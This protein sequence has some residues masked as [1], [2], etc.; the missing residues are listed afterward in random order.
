MIST[1]K[2]SPTRKEQLA[3]EKEKK[4]TYYNTNAIIGLLM[5]TAAW[6][7]VK[8][9]PAIAATSMTDKCKRDQKRRSRVQTTVNGTPIE[10]LMDS[11]A[12]VSI[13]S[14]KSFKTVGDKE[15]T[16]A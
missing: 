15:G 11:G 3:L 7:N 16:H 8:V 2:G 1:S 9:L 6:I 13:M 14:K 12:S 5:C 10:A 4:C